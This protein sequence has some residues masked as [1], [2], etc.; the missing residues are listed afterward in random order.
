MGSEPEQ[1]TNQQSK[2]D[3]SKLYLVIKFTEKTSD[4]INEKLY[5][6]FSRCAG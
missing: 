4:I 1:R 5:K 3:V 6:M 2:E